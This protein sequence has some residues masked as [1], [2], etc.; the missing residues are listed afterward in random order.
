VFHPD[1]LYIRQCL[2]IER[3]ILRLPRNG[4]GIVARDDVRGHQFLSVGQDRIRLNDPLVTLVAPDILDTHISAGQKRAG[5]S[6]NQVLL[7][8]I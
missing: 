3:S 2:A 7:T 8:R 6:A 4:I 1:F 5:I